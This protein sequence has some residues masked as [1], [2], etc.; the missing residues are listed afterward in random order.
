MIA[1]NCHSI[2]ELPFLEG[3]DESTVAFTVYTIR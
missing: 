2:I 1:T 3:F